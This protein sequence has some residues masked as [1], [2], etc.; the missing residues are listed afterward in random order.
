MS[1]KEV[2]L[3][4]HSNGHCFL[5]FRDKSK[6]KRSY[7]ISIVGMAGALIVPVHVFVSLKN[8]S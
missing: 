6:K 1:E 5:I 7:G 8:K 2:S 3:F 4:Y